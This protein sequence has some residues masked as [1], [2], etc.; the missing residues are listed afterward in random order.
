MALFLEER[1]AKFLIQTQTPGL[2]PGHYQKP[3]L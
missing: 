1:D 3:I 2:G